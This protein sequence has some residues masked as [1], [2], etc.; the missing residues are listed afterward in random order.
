V[1]HDIIDNRNHILIDHIRRILPG[2][3]GAKFAVGYFLLSGLEAVSD[4]LESVAELRLLI[5]NTSNRQ[6]IEQIAEGYRRLAQVEK[7]AE[8]LTMPRR[9]DEARMAEA[10]RSHSAASSS[11]GA[12]CAAGATPM[13]RLAAAHPKQHD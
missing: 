4:V 5:G 9:V 7:A 11:C 10:S 2:S 13:R 8:E 6:T 3:E 12:G 1:P